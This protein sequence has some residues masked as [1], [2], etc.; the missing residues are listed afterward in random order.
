MVN[1]G[2]F[3]RNKAFLD[4]ASLAHMYHSLVEMYHSLAE[5]YHSYIRLV[6]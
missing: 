5:M 3:L 4:D 6:F 2:R 1:E